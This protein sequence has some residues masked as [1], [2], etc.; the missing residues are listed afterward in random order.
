MLYSIGINS[1]Y[2][3]PA[4]A[5]PMLWSINALGREENDV[6]YTCRWINVQIIWRT[7]ALISLVFRKDFVYGSGDIRC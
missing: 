7:F 2:H 3:L 4:I 6:K 5:I 1:S